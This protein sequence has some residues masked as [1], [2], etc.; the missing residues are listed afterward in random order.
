M[1]RIRIDDLPVAENLTPEQ[2]ALIQGAGLKS[3]RPGLE[4]L[5]GRDVPAVIAPGIDLTGTTLTFQVRGT[6]ARQPYSSYTANAWTNAE[7]QVVAQRVDAGLTGRAVFLDRS[8][9]TKI[10]YEGTPGHDTFNNY[11]GIESS[12]TNLN[13][14]GRDAHNVETISAAPSDITGFQVTSSTFTGGHSLPDSSA[15]SGVRRGGVELTEAKNVAPPLSWG[16]HPEALSYAVVTKDI[17]VPGATPT[18]AKETHIHQAI[19]NIPNT[20]LS[21][22]SAEALSTGAGQRYEGPNPPDGRE[23][24]YVTTV[25]ALK[26]ANL[27]LRGMN[28]DQIEAAIQAQSV[29]QTSISGKFQADVNSTVWDTATNNWKPLPQT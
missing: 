11:T 21:L 8:Q 15:V 20:K 12:F 29:G 1:T 14:Q 9:V 16:A 13:A 24:T 26:V 5:E 17:S 3:F 7:N 2:E 10:V 18:A 25:Y 6:T 23:H 19:A 27:D 4:K 28:R 22:S